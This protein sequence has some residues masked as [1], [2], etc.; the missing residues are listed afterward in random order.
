LPDLLL[1]QNRHVAGDLANHAV[2]GAQ[3]VSERGHDHEV[4]V[5]DELAFA[6]DLHLARLRQ[7]LHDMEIEIDE[8]RFQQEVAPSLP[9]QD[10]KRIAPVRQHG[11]LRRVDCAHQIGPS[12]AQLGAQRQGVQEETADVLAVHGLGPAIRRHP[13]EDVRGPSQVAHHPAVRGQQN[14]FE[15][16]ALDPRQVPQRNEEIRRQLHRDAAPALLARFRDLLPPSRH[17][18]GGGAVQP[19]PPEVTGLLRLQSHPFEL[20]EVPKGG[21]QRWQIGKSLATEK[22]EITDQDLPVERVQAP[23]VEDRVVLHRRELQPVIGS[24]VEMKTDLRI[25]RQVERPCE[26]LTPSVL[27]PRLLRFVAQGAQ[28]FERQSQAGLAVNELQRLLIPRQIE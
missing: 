4:R 24:P 1:F 26:L 5:F 20:H 25:A 11:D 28:I 19:S 14:A 6:R 18:K 13:G 22:G 23:A 27:D 3:A 16:H 21:C 7:V 9:L 8:R 10:G 12:A 2:L 15:R 17:S